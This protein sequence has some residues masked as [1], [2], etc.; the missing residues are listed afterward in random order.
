MSRSWLLEG[1]YGRLKHFR[2]KENL[3][4]SLKFKDYMTN[5]K[6]ERSWLKQCVGGW[7]GGWQSLRPGTLDLGWGSNDP[8]A[9]SLP[10]YLMDLRILLG[11][12]WKR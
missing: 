3:V 1:E 4:L 11:I 10:T 12:P 9:P 5:L 2:Q 8:T 6:Y 7:G